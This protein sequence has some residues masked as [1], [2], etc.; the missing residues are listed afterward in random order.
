MRY[1]KL[2]MTESDACL[3]WELYDREYRPIVP[4]EIFAEEERHVLKITDEEGRLAA[5]C[6]FDVD[7]RTGRTLFVEPIFI[8]E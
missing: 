4:P 7:D 5:G 6:V 8:Q 2:P 3:L 1:K